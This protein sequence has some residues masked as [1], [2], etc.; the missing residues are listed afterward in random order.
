MTSAR[1]RVAAVVTTAA[2]ALALTPSIGSAQPSGSPVRAA[3]AGQADPNPDVVLR[4]RGWGHSVGLSQYGAF[5]QAKAGRDVATILDHYYPGTTLGSYAA[6]QA[7]QVTVRLGPLSGDLADQGSPVRAIGGDV[8]WRSTAT[9]STVSQPRDAVWRV[10]RHPDAAY[11]SRVQLVDADGDVRAE[12]D[13]VL[14]AELSSPTVRTDRATPRV[15]AH[16]PNV[17]GGRE[18]EA[19]H[20]EYSVSDRTLDLHQR[21]P[22]ENY[23]RGIAEVPAGWGNAG[24]QAALEAQAVIA[25]SYVLQR[26][27][28]TCATPACQVYNGYSKQAD[29]AGDRWVAAVDATRGQVV[30]TAQG[31][32]AQTYYSSSHG[33][34]TEAS[35]DSWA[36]G[37]TVPY[38]RS[39]DDPWSLEEPTNHLRSWSATVGNAEFRRV[40]G[41]GLSRVEQ[42]EILDR[43]DGG[44]PATL[45]VRGPQG[46]VT[47]TT[48]PQTRRTSRACNRRHAGNSLRCDLTGATVRN[49]R[50]QTF[51]A[52]GGQPPST[53]ILYIGFPPFVDD[54]GGTHEYATVWAHA[55]GI[56]EGVDQAQTLFRPTHAVSRA[57]MAAFLYR[58]FDVP[59]TREHAFTD[60]D[61]DHHHREAI[62]SVA[63]GGI[64]E[65]RADGSFRPNA[66]VTR[67][68]MATFLARALG[69]EPRDPGFTDVV[70]DDEH[71]RN[72]GALAASGI[73]GGC[74][75]DGRRYCP[76]NPVQRGQMTSFL[77]RA[78]RAQ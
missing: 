27:R 17:A 35:E 3:V 1:G 76:T 41:G 19:G 7:Q 4:G 2:V 61:P 44:S 46:T 69:L 20:L 38:L 32:I 78:V 25:R 54:D 37:G 14:R 73:T 52:A 50:G 65:G 63:A 24:G 72:V 42:V 47:F 59:A 23:V 71:G 15:L 12:R 31:A 22:L 18:Y 6:D 74:S 67:A 75:E 64:A 45:R 29:T 30:R 21:L 57:Q 43:T 58:T 36:Y 55:A 11:T 70:A 68:Q 39:V 40:A 34:R 49:H 28:S 48:T 9:G 26:G 10:R 51:A 5:A 13:G 66:P 16:S 8:T 53:Q 33:G 77:H 56:A 60:V 62:A